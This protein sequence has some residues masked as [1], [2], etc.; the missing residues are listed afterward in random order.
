MYPHDNIFNIYYNIGKRTP[1]LVKRCELG[2]AR[3]SSEERRIDPNQDRTFLVETVKPRGKYGKAYG[4]C[5]VNG[6]PDDT[7]R[8]ECYPNIKDEEI[9]CA[10]CGEWVY[11]MFRAYLLMKYFLFTKRMR[12]LWLG[13]IKGN[14]LEIFI[15]WIINIFIG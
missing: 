7:Y 9:P 2:L 15:R 14:L 4:K 11:L 5:F 8:K 13:N 6:K 1:F 10:G 3:S 12:Y